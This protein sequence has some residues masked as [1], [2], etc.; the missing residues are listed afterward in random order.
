M[1]R[2]SSTGKIGMYLL[3][4]ALKEDNGLI[5]RKGIVTRSNDYRDNDRII[6]LFTTDAK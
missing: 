6:N 3:Y 1:G 5:I 2:F 4:R